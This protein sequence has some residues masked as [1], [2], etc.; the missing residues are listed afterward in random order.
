MNSENDFIPT[1]YSGVLNARLQ[2]EH[3]INSTILTFYISIQWFLLHPFE[4]LIKP[5]TIL[6]YRPMRLP[7]FDNSV[8]EMRRGLKVLACCLRVI[9]E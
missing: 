4:H 5:A 9:V 1:P 7:F 2:Q 8:K 6:R 3:E